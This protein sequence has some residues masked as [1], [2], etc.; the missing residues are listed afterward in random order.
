M[1]SKIKSFKV[2]NCR[3]CNSKKLYNYINLGNQPPSNSF[4]KKKDISKQ[5]KFPLKVILCKDCGL[6]QL[7][8]VVLSIGIFDKYS[9]LSSTSKALIK[10]YE[11]MVKKI[12]Q[13]FRPKKNDLIIDIGCNDGITL[14]LYQKNEYSLLGIE[15]SSAYFYA[16]KKK[17]NVIKRFFNFKLS[18]KIKKK[19]GEAKIIT[20]TNVFAHNHDINDFTKGIKNLLDKQ[21]GVFVIEF[22]YIRDMLKQLYF[23]TIYH[24]HLSYFA[25]SPLKILF[26]NHGL[27]IFDYEKTLVGASGP[28]MRIYVSHID[29]KY[30][31][32]KKI[33]DIL[34]TEKKWGVKKIKAY[35]KFSNDVKKL[36]IALLKIIKRTGVKNKLIGAYGAPAK[37]NT[38]LNYLG[39][40]SKQIFAIADNSIT[41]INHYAPG[42]N[43]KVISDEEFLKIDCKYAV[44]L[45]WNYADFFLKNSK[46]ILNNGKFILPLPKPKI[47]PNE[48][49]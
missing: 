38:L 4:V 6:S 9:Y 31:I 10:N 22:P 49:N 24:E 8:T 15:P 7:D 39:L 18:Q 47:I 35:K 20:A 29:S 25:I 33:N 37:G 2:K 45:A 16:K 26:Q 34:K 13:R 17:F 48:K 11:I 19:S 14:D 23:D 43:I 5:K 40:N 27:K 32:S 21:S 12:I 46:F 1:S 42:S 36:K 3:I 44:L 30:R 28:A 41:K